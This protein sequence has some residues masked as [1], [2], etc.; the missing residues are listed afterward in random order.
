MICYRI[1][2]MDYIIHASSEGFTSYYITYRFPKPNG[3]ITVDDINHYGSYDVWK[4]DVAA[5]KCFFP[6][7]EY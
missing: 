3:R 2:P 4:A 6:N 1:N 5:E 7:L